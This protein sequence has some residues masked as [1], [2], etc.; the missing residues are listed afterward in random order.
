MVAQ[1]EHVELKI[2]F[3]KK[4][5]GSRICS[6]LE[7]DDITEIMVNPDSSVWFESRE[8]G[9]YKDSELGE[10]EAQ[11]FLMQLA[12][13]RDLFL[14]FENPYIETLLPF[15]RERLE[16]TIAPVTDRAAFTIRKRARCVYALED[17]CE[18]GIL[19]QAQLD[20]IGQA[21]VD[22]KNMLVSGGPGTGKTTLTNAIVKKMADLCEASQRILVLEDTAEIQCSMPNVLSM[23]TSPTISMQTLLKI[24]MRSRPDRILVGEVRDSAALDLLKSWNTGCPGGLAT[25]HAN[26]TESS[27]LRLLSLAQEANV[28]PPY[29]LVAETIDVMINI[30]R[31]TQHPA[32]RRVQAI[33]KMKGW[34]G[35]AFEC[36]T[37]G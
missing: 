2:D 26:S 18:R 37:I 3:M 16:G 6:A 10:F 9:M 30:V 24:A 12:R 35:L 34:N 13:L 17:Y 23:I 29:M 32:G 7:D 22:R 5:L 4:M 11:N 15:N 19:S 36:E 20:F 25:I 31:D 28:P 21:I 8:Q 1:P 14:N 33:S 27:L